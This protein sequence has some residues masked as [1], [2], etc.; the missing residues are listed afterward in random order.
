MKT[1]LIIPSLGEGYDNHRN[2]KLLLGGIEILV[3]T[4]IER[5]FADVS[6]L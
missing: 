4:R 3:F 1:T 2:E 6:H 5:I